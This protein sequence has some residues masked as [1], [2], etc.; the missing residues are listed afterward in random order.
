MIRLN[1]SDI[2]R[3]G[4][5]LSILKIFRRDAR[6]RSSERGFGYSELYEV[7]K[8]S[9]VKYIIIEQQQFTET[10]LKSAEMS[11]HF[12]QRLIKGPQGVKG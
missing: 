8:Q 5:R 4:C 12:M 10:S 9:G 2:I 6:I 7:V 11:F 3:I 1:T